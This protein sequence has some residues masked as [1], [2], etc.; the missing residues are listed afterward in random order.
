MTDSLSVRPYLHASD[1]QAIADICKDVYNGH[2]YMPR[3]IGS[4]ASDPAYLL[5]AAN[6]CD[7]EGKGR[8]VGIIGSH[9]RGGMVFLFGLRV[10][11]NERG[12]GVAKL[13]SSKIIQQSML[14]FPTASCV[15]T[16]TVPENKAAISIFGKLLG[17]SQVPRDVVHLWPPSEELHQYE[18]S[19]GWPGEAAENKTPMLDHWPWLMNILRADTGAVERINHWKPVEE[20][21]SLLRTILSI[22]SSS[23]TTEPTLDG[24]LPGMYEPISIHSEEMGLAIR[25]Q[26]V[27][28]LPSPR[29]IS[30]SCDGPADAAGDAALILYTSREARGRLVVGITA[31]GEEEIHSALLFCHQKL[32]VRHLML[33]I[34]QPTASTD[35]KE[36]SVVASSKIFQAFGSKRDS[37]ITFGRT[38]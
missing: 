12:R 30:A 1:Y 23:R 37:F 29:S 9:L 6:S 13:L 10:K 24:W 17:E 8:L 27:W 19:I 38:S 26:R 15:Y 14:N 5:L 33:F 16:V 28:V 32:H 3:M 21:D 34:N 36:G 11:E 25:D 35:G 31:R 20:K 22:Q 7:T 4:Y 18:E 2:D